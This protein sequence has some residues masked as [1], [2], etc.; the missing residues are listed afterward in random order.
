MV[1]S[2][3]NNATKIF[4]F[5]IKNIE[6]KGN[7]RE[8][9][10]DYA[11]FQRPRR[12]PSP[13]RAQSTLPLNLSKEDKDVMQLPS[14]M[15]SPFSPRGDS[16]PRRRENP[17]SW[18]TY[19]LSRSMLMDSPNKSRT[20]SPKFKQPVKIKEEKIKEF[21]QEIGKR[22]VLDKQDQL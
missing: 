10:R 2:C 15:F 21:G 1:N 4:P 14:K 22:W 6:F 19:S 8:I 5:T 16:P 13:V 18:C 9:H 20:P 12:S 3:Q 7:S 11:Q 17:A